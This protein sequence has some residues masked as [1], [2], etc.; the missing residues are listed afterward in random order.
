V[1]RLQLT[2][3]SAELTVST[4]NQGHV[5]FCALILDFDEKQFFNGKFTRNR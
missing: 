2:A 1:G 5:R 3:I 4:E